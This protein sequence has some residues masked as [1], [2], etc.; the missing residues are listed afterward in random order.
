[1]NT[2]GSLTLGGYD[3]SR[4]KPNDVSFTF[5]PNVNRDLV[6]GLQSISFSDSATSNMPLLPTGSGILALIDSTI[7][8]LW[9]PAE[10][11]S[12]FE[13]A[14]GISL[15]PIHSLYIVNDTQHEQLLK[16][17][18][19]VTFQLGNSVDG[20]STVDVVLPYES[21]D[22]VIGPPLLPNTTRYFP[23]HQASAS[24]QYTLG[25]I[26]LQEA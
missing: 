16:Q 2:T 6:V 5:E 23:L 13:K 26:L 9:L 20:G 12:E 4:F 19:S 8:D 15:D 25:R 10:V 21:F 14:F 24:S 3:A 11:C 17:N 22:L 7:P 18:A 1:M